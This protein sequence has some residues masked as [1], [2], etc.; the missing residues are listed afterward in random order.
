MY[1]SGLRKVFV[2][3][4]FCNLFGYQIKK[5]NP[6]NKKQKQ[7]QKNETKQTK[8]KIIIHTSSFQNLSVYMSHMTRFRL[9]DVVNIKYLWSFGVGEIQKD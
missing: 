6:K 2:N 9:S 3:S 5:K 8:K 7:K 1:I 4:H